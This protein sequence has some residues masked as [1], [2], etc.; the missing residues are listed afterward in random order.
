MKNN[1]FEIVNARIASASLYY[2]ERIDGLTSFIQLDY[3]DSSCQGF[4]G[5]LLSKDS[6]PSKTAGYFILKVL[7][8]AGAEDW[9]G[10]SGCVVRVKREN[11]YNGRVI[12]IGH[13]MKDIWYSL[14]EP[15]PQ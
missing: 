3:G 8:I 10:L 6:N 12:A 11:S 9:R 1:N 2:E 4:G 14:D 5:L 7:S 13:I 15:A